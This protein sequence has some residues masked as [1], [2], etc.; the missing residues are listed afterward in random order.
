MK[1]NGGEGGGG[2]GGGGRKGGMGGASTLQ[3][4]QIWTKFYKP[5]MLGFSLSNK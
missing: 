3:P 5:F 2:G 1:E 4:S